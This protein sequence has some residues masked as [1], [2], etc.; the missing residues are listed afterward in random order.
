MTRL[1]S[2][3]RD[4]QPQVSHLSLPLG[5]GGGVVKAQFTPFPSQGSVT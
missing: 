1:G 2:Q 3:G 5:L 4:P